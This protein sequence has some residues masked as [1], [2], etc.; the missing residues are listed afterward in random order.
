MVCGYGWAYVSGLRMQ[1]TPTA[2]RKKKV[3]YRLLPS[4]K[5]AI[6]NKPRGFDEIKATVQKHFAKGSFLALS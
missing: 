2:T 1:S 4:N 6:K 3:T 5:K